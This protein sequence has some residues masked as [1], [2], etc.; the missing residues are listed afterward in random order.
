MVCFIWDIWR[1][2]LFGKGGIFLC[3]VGILRGIVR[4]VDREVEVV[5]RSLW[6]FWGKGVVF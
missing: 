5:G 6:V 3:G 4:R 2:G 1:C